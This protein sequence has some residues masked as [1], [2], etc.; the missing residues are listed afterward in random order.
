MKT[1]WWFFIILFA[2]ILFQTGCKTEYGYLL[3]TNIENQSNY[4]IEIK[5]GVSG[6]EI[7]DHFFISK[8]ETY[9]Y[10]IETEGGPYGFPY[11]GRAL[12]RFGDQVQTLHRMVDG[13][14]YHN[15]CSENAYTLDIPEKR[16]KEYTF[17][18][19][20]ADYEYAIE[21]PAESDEWPDKKSIEFR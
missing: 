16:T 15:Y 7:P 4:D 6:A 19:T 5:A 1:K 2:G 17:T 21:H 8:G 13:D 18:F 14:L 10:V 20:D 11:S 12:I 9:T 3:I